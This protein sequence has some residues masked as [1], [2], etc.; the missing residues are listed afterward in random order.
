MGKKIEPHMIAAA[1]DIAGEETAYWD[2]G[3]CGD[4]WC[5]DGWLDI[6]KFVEHLNKVIAESE[7]D[8]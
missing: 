8:G 7:T 3:S 4:L 6:N 1:L 2:C 5:L